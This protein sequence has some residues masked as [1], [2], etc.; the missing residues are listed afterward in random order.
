MYIKPCRTCPQTAVG[1]QKHHE[2]ASAAHA[3]GLTS[4]F[5][6]CAEHAALFPVGRTV[7][8]TLRFETCGAEEYSGALYY[9][10]DIECIVTHLRRDKF[11]LWPISDETDKIFITAFADRL[12]LLNGRPI[13]EICPECHKPNHIERDGWLCDTCGISYDSTVIMESLSRVSVTL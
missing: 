7:E 8:I 4:G 13:A 12:T 10:E 2:V 9:F 5:Y 1:C 3:I 11:W 6:K